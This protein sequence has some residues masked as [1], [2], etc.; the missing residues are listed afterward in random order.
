MNLRDASGT[1]SVRAQ[2]LYCGNPDAPCFATLYTPLET[3]QRAPGW[4]LCP[5]LGQERGNTHTLFANWARALCA[6]GRPV[7][8]FDYRGYGDSACAEETCTLDDHIADTLEVIRLHESLTGTQCGGLCGMRMGATIAALTAEAVEHPLRL[9]LWDPIVDGSQYTHNLLRTSMATDLA[10]GA[11]PVSCDQRREQ[12]KQGARLIAD[13]HVITGETFSAMATVDLL[14]RPPPDCAL[15]IQCDKRPMTTLRP[16]LKKLVCAWETSTR[17]ATRHVQI[18]LPWQLGPDYQPSPEPLFRPSLAWIDQNE[19][20]DIAPEVP[21]GRHKVLAPRGAFVG[22]V[23]VE[24][25]VNFKSGSLR[26]QGILH[27]PVGANPHHPLLILPPPGTDTRSGYLRNYVRLARSMA[28]KGWSCLRYDPPGIGASPGPSRKLPR[29][30]HNRYV[31][32]GGH[33]PDLRAATDAFAPH[34]PVI[35]GGI[36]GG[37][38]SAIRYADK[39]PRVAGL[40]I[41]EP[42]FRW[43][44]LPGKA[45]GVPLWAYRRR[46]LSRPAWKRLL[47]FKTHYRD[48]WHA[49]LSAIAHT[50]RHGSQQEDPLLNR[51]LVNA[52]RRCIDRGLPTLILYGGTDDQAHYHRLETVLYGKRR[53]APAN[54]REQFLNDADHAFSE[55]AHTNELINIVDQW[56]NDR[57]HAWSKGPGTPRHRMPSSKPPLSTYS[58]ECQNRPPQE[59]RHCRPSGQDRLKH[60]F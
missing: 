14:Q 17:I 42:Q 47:T 43:T 32:R 37:A 13:G 59:S 15:I 1:E 19:S 4:I 53:T 16:D 55:P 38:I 36:C 57:H 51:T 48:L 45:T 2:H 3:R 33:V 39:D 46:L 10:R 52:F 9:L 24:R 6:T 7:L 54:V 27:T 25:P 50:F 56:L 26:L 35:V 20:A 29:A 21:Y 41:I 8:H 18:P 60:T 58:H 23:D 28:A 44:P 49:F 22:N 34:G 12:L 31:Q 11:R 40:I 5:P 30:E